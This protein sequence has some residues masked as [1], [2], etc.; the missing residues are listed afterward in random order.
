LLFDAR[1]TAPGSGNPTGEGDLLTL[2]EVQVTAPAPTTPP[3]TQPAGSTD[4]DALTLIVNGQTWEG[5]QRVWVTRSIDG[6]PAQFRIEVTEKYPNS[7]DI[8]IEPGQGCQ[9][10]IGQDLVLTG[11]IDRYQPVLRADLHV[12]RIWGR[13]LSEDLIDCA[14]FFGDPANP[15][16]TLNSGGTAL[17]IAQ[18]LAQPYNVTIQGEA[19]ANPIPAF[20]IIPGETVWQIVDRMLRQAQL[21]AY[22]NTDG[23]VQF[24]QAGAGAMA[25]G[26]TQGENVEWAQPT[27]SMD[28]RFSQYQAF[29]VA[30]Q[31]FLFQAGAAVA[32]DGW[33]YDN[34]VPRLRKRI[35][36]TD[37]TWYGQSIAQARAVWE[38]NR[39][40]GRSQAVL[41]RCDNWRD[42]A[43]TLWQINNTAPL[44]LPA[45]KVTPTA[46]WVIGTVVFQRDE[47]GQHAMVTMMPAAAFLPEPVGNM[48]IWSPTAPGANNPT[49]TGNPT[50]N[51]AAIPPGSPVVAGTPGAPAG[52]AIAPPTS[53]PASP[54][55]SPPPVPP[56][57]R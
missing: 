30:S 52:P 42:S 33:A 11:W 26:F 19:G 35:I 48:S 4:P 9:V 32:T 1:G 27:L 38:A 53:P 24:A 21:I 3:S 36:I 57:R 51:P 6:M 54:G 46:D 23:S 5:W 50:Y 31:A 15:T 39:A 7:P 28:Q 56:V 13:S 47:Q 14:A 55:P 20:A 17:S 10:M 34:G 45:V 25:S 18:Q 49:A 8:D 43:G 12:V 16:F 44:Y 37:Q 22:D 41:L 40:W 2:D 29:T